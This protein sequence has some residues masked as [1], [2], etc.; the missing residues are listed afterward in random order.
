LPGRGLRQDV[1]REG[2]PREAHPR[3]AQRLMYLLDRLV[4]EV[5]T[6]QLAP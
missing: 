4:A 5:Q 3:D 1:C 6:L 2:Q